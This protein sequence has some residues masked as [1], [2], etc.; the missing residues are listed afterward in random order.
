MSTEVATLASTVQSLNNGQIAVYSS[1]KGD[2]FDTKVAVLAATTNAA[3]LNENFGKTINLVNVVVQ[4]IDIESLNEKTGEVEVNEAVRTV[5]LDADGTSYYAVSGG[6]FKA[7]TNMF[8][9]LGEPHV[10]VKPLTIHVVEE[11]SKKNA[12]HRYMT[13]KLGAAE[14]A[15]K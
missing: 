10:W 15:K 5:L 3:P 14:T 12:A 1:M 11:R 2:D 13:V 4:A 9:I 6:I 7:L 8:G